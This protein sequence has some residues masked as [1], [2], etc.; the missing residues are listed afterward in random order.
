FLVLVRLSRI[1]DT[2]VLIL[3]VNGCD[4]RLQRLHLFH[5]LQAGVFQRQQKKIDGDGDHHDGP[6]VVVNVL[7]VHP[8]ERQKQGLG[9]DS[10]PTEV[11]DVRKFRVHATQQIDVFR[12]QKHG[13]AVDAIASDR[14]AHVRLLFA[15]VDYRSDRILETLDFYLTLRQ[16]DSSEKCVFDTG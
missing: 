8:V 16:H 11:H 1:P 12:S 15:R 6:A 3:V 7:V 10:K 9:Q 4:L 5:R 2:D 13:E 14:D